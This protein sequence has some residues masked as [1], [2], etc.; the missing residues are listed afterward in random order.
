MK[1]EAAVPL[2]FAGSS[3]LPVWLLT[4]ESVSERFG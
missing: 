2:C 1:L 4:S 3:V